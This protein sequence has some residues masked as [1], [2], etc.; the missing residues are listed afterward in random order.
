V[1]QAEAWLDRAE[2]S[3]TYFAN[4]GCG[5]GVIGWDRPRPDAGFFDVFALNRDIHRAYEIA[6]GIQETEN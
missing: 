2:A 3:L 5:C 4:W 1:A 6:A